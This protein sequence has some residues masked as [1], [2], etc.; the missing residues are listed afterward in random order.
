MKW[1]NSIQYFLIVIFFGFLG[2]VF[3]YFH[4]LQNRNLFPGRQ[5]LTALEFEV[6][7]PFTQK[8]EAQIPKISPFEN[9]RLEAKAAY[10]FDASNNQSVFELNSE[11]QLP[12]ASLAKIMT[13]LIAKENLPPYLLITISKE[14]VLQEGD[15]GFKVGEQ[16]IISELIDAMLISSS[17][18]AAFAFAEEFDNNFNG[19]FVSL[20]SRKAKEI[21][22]TQTYFLNATGLDLSKNTS[23]A[24]G[25]AKDIAKLLLYIAK[26]DSSLMEATRLE[27]I[28]LHG[29]EFQN[30]NRVI[31]DLP[32]FIAGKT[33]FS[34][35]A[36]S[37][38][39]VVVD[40]GFNRPFVIVVLGSTIDGRF[41]DIKNLFN[42]AV[43][44]TEN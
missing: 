29:W 3:F 42:A 14:A 28:N 39:A 17:N 26:K 25:S 5:K 36:G 18:D 35:L 38:L 22:L 20:M 16:W 1:Q 8:Q 32:G 7:N 21:G 40:N 37:N 41:N 33:G 12:L 4:P 31:E 44:E 34:D 30:T 23:G 19:D 10:V 2:W 15:A 27:S 9:I 13:A 43:A 6:K 24:Y 11:M